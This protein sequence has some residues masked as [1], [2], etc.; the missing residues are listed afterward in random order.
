VRQVIEEQ[1]ALSKGKT[2]SK[3]ITICNLINQGRRY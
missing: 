1:K 3:G 2:F